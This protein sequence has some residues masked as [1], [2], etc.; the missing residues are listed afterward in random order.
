LA[1]GRIVSLGWH[2]RDPYS[3][4][5]VGFNYASY[6]GLFQY[7]GYANLLSNLHARHVT[8]LVA[9]DG[10]RLRFDAVYKPAEVP[11]ARFERWGVAWYL[12]ARNAEDPG[13]TAHYE[14]LLSRRGLRRVAEDSRRIVFHDP[15]AEPLVY[16]VVADERRRGETPTAGGEPT[17]RRGPADEQGIRD[18]AGREPLQPRVGGRSL[19]VRFAPSTRARTLVACFLAVPGFTAATLDGRSLPLSSD[20]GRMTVDVPAGVGDVCLVY[21]EPALTRG[22]LHA[23]LLLALPLVVWAGSRR[24]RRQP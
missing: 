2:A 3:S 17:S 20:G 22:L 21:H 9:D 24:L 23:A 15:R 13:E 11:F 19:T 12:L 10:R 8:G 1:S 7:A 6:W 16:L 14:E 4:A 18:V 5:Q